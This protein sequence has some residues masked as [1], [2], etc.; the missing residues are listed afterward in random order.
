[1]TALAVI[2]A[3]LLPRHPPTETETTREPAE[4]ATPEP[5]AM[6]GA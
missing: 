4:A 3:V 5:A 2:P 1:M 6:L